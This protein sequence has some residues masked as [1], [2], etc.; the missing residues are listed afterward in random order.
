MIR[1]MSTKY[2]K[3][4]VTYTTWKDATVV[5]TH[6]REEGR[7]SSCSWECTAGG[8]GAHDGHW[9]FA[10]L[11][12]AADALEHAQ[13]DEDPSSK[14]AQ[15]QGPP[16]RA[17]VVEALTVHYTQHTLTATYKTTSSTTAKKQLSPN[18]LKL[19]QKHI[20][21]I[22]LLFHNWFLTFILTVILRLGWTLH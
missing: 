8:E 21:Y 20:F 2:G 14:E 3:V 22:C 4:A 13:E 6:L 10:H 16:H 12:R 19:Q 7:P 18:Q 9:L 17:G 11:A 1:T 5:Q 15:G